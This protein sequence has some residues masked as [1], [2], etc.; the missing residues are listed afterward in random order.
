MKLSH[1]LGLCFFFGLSACQSTDS[2]NMNA[3]YKSALIATEKWGEID[4]QDVNL[5]TLQNKNGMQLQL[6]NYGALIVKA[7]VPDRNGEFADV[8]L[9]YP[10]LE[11]YQRERAGMGAVI[12]RYHN[13]IR[14]GQFELEGE[15][16]QVTLNEGENS[17]HAGFEYQRALWTA[18]AITTDNGPGLQLTYVSPDG[19]HGFPGEVRTTLTYV[20]TEDNAIDLRFEAGADR[21]TPL[22]YIQHAYFNLNGVSDTVLKHVVSI[23]ADTHAAYDS[24]ALQTGR[25]ESLRG[26][27]FDLIEPTEIG[28]HLDEI[29]L[30]GYHQTYILN[31]KDGELKTIASIWDPE[32]GRTMDV[33]TTSPTMTFY[34]SMGLNNSVPGKYGIEYAPFKGFCMETGFIPD[35]VNYPHLPSTIFGPD[36]RYDERVIYRFGVKP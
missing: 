2:S 17:I 16:Y 36:R 6:S 21:P 20:L 19:S 22:N 34:V 9:G 27:A 23:D 33:S 30:G 18:L 26:E 13:R 4:G 25:I 28:A 11:D 35:S 1:L 12:G 3:A 32:S 5:Y 31:K 10:T 24:S 7:L 8:A 15:Q 29:A 14:N